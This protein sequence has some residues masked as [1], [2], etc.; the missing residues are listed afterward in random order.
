MLKYLQRCGVSKRKI[1]RCNPGTRLYHDLAVYGDIA[2]TFMEVL[3][4]EYDVDMSYFKFDEFF[5]QEFQGKDRLTAIMLWVVPF[6]GGLARRRG[7]YRP[8]TLEMIE[9]VI[10][11][12]QWRIIERG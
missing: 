11:A 2:K 4:D 1:A 9:K 5:P 3:R 7:A 8:L 6:V 10:E 12:K